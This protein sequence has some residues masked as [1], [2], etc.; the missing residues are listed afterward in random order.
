MVKNLLKLKHKL[1]LTHQ[2]IQIPYEDYIFLKCIDSF[3]GK[4]TD[5]LINIERSPINKISHLNKKWNITINMYIVIK[6]NLIENQ[7]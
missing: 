7:N 5:W 1:Y 4:Y 3:F 2:T 6:S